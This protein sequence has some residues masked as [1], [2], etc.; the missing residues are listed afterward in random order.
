[1][2][3]NWKR[4]IAL[5]LSSQTISLFGSSLVQYAILWYITLETESG[6]MMTLSIISGFLPTFFLSPF[7]GVWADRHNRKMLIALADALVAAATL[8]IA[9]LFMADYRSV[10]LLFAGSAVRAVGTGIQTPAV[11]AVIPSIVPEEQLTRVNGIN[12]TIQALVTLVSPMV[13]AAL[14]TAIPLEYIFFIDVAT[15]AVAI[16]TMVF[17]V[18]VPVHAKAMQA[19]TTSYFTDMREGLVYISQHAYLKAYFT[20]C[21]V[22]FVLAAPVSFLTPLQVTRSFGD[23]VWRLSGIEVTF[24]IGMM[25]GGLL[26]ASWGGFRNRVHTMTLSSLVTGLCTFLLGVVH[27]FW[28]YL[29]IMGIIGV[30]MPVFNTPATVLLQERVEPDYLGRVFGAMTMIASS[31]MPLGMLVFGPIADLI[32][33]EWLLVGTGLALFLQAFLLLASRPLVE[34]GEPLMGQS[35]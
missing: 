20:F 30:A 3:P 18:Q 8:V 1:M 22:F 7:A 21:A 17:F 5:F 16:F 34:A 35:D 9:V 10:W 19:K 28:L 29:L 31:M 32:P 4:N 27:I 6:F 23:E 2:K 13:S 26:M 14:Y 25:L 33:I 11:S 12:S 15:A 24:A